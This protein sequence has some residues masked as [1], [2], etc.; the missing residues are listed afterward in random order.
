MSSKSFEVVKSSI[1]SVYIEPKNIFRIPRFQRQYTWE[2]KQIEEFWDTIN[3]EQAIFL[4]TI[5]FD[6]RDKTSNKITEIIDG[7]QRYLTIQI[8]GS[9][10]R[11]IILKLGNAEKDLKYKQKAAG[12]HKRILGRQDVDDDDVFYN[13]LITGDS[14]KTFFEK[15]I[16][17][18][19][20]LEITEELVV[21]KNSE[22]ERVKKAYLKFHEL[23][24]N[25]IANKSYDEKIDWLKELISIKLGQHYFVKIEIEDED[26]AYEI[27]ETVNAKGVDLS[28]AD[29]IKNQI[30]KHVIGSHDKYLDTAK[31]Q[32]GSI[33]ETLNDIE[34]S[35]KD[36]L[37]YYW[38]SK[39]E[40]VTD[41]KLYSAI[42][43]K[44]KNDKKKWE[45]FLS[46]LKN[47][48]EYL[49]IIVSGSIDDV[50]IHFGDD[51]N[52]G[53]K[54]Y[55]SLRVL[56]NTNAKTWIVLY[57]CLFRNLDSSNDKK[58]NIPF[59]LA[60]RWQIIEKFT[61]LY[62]QIL[63]AQGN[64]YFKLIKDFSK[65]LE[66]Y[67]TAGKSKEEYINLFIKEL[68]THFKNKLPTFTV[69]EEGFES[70]QY[71]DDKKSR[72][73][74]RYILNELEEKIGGNLN[75]GYDEGKVSIE[76]VLP[77]APKEWGLTKKI[78]K[79]HVNKL[80]NLTLIGKALNGKM[81][82]KPLSDKIEIAKGSN[83]KLVS[84]LLENIEKKEW[85]FYRISSDKDFT[86]IEKRLEYLS[87][88]ANE[89][90]VDDLRKRMG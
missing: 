83:I 47:N 55:N 18:N 2:E 42:R 50:F 51:K 48:S 90:W 23:I 62:F 68:F 16:Q 85:D 6:V 14:I 79:S 13:Y 84:Q 40:Y 72:I 9:V 1:N 31:S 53:E 34:F 74:I 24:S 61:F 87:K 32:W 86:A 30:F 28:V 26:L 82:N 64:W 7:Q 60:N 36:F 81:G 45:N 63:N 58:P 43:E 3:S 67:V 75:E 8:L 17:N 41:K 11:N 4:G 19:P 38:T 22:E 5:I 89:I 44:F 46:D 49:R 21:L 76:H 35:L 77:Q 65:Q 71:R 80:G 39:Y 78:I 37:S 52:E 33:L 56:R 57:L 66:I 59:A 29:L 12:I 73:I 15:Y 54:V 69:F 70:I 27:F 20:S 88:I 10:V 25:I